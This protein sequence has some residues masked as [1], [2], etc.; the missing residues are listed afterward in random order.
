MLLDWNGC[1]DGINDFDKFF[2]F[3]PGLVFI[4]R[5]DHLIFELSW[6]IWRDRIHSLVLWSHGF[7]CCDVMML[8]QFVDLG[9]VIIIL[10]LTFLL[11]SSPTFLF[12]LRRFFFMFIFNFILFLFFSL[13]LAL[14]RPRLSSVRPSQ[15]IRPKFGFQNHAEQVLG[16]MVINLQKYWSNPQKILRAITTQDSPRLEFFP[17]HTL[18][19]SSR[20]SFASSMLA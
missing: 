8:K 10:S 17:Q 18:N 3:N 1:C 12:T 4:E 15:T 11:L 16:P 7:G 14:L 5:I 13:P 6:T 20:S 9:L 2:P 19:S